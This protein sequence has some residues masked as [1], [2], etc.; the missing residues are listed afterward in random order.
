LAS[1]PRIAARLV[2]RLAAEDGVALVLGLTV[3]TVLAIVATTTVAYATQNEGSTRRSARDS[4]SYALAEAGVN[5]AAAMLGAPGRNPLDPSLLPQTTTT[6]GDGTYTRWGVLNEATGVW[7]ITSVGRTRNPTGPAVA[8][9]TRTLTVTV[10]VMPAPAQPLT[11]QAW[12]YIYSRQ[13]GLTCDMTIG[14]TVQVSSPLYVAGSLCLQNTA[15]ITKGP[16]Y[17]GGRLTMTQTANAVGSAAAPVSEA[18]IAGGCRWSTNTMHTP[19]VGGAGT[20]GFDNVWATKFD[21]TPGALAPPVPQYDSWYLNASPGP[22]YPCATVSGTPPAFD[23]DQGARTSPDA[24][25]RND[26]L[27]ALPV[28]DLTPPSSYTCKTS[29]GELSWD[30]ASRVLTVNGTVFIDGSAKVSNGMVNSYSGIGSLYLSGTLLVKGSKLCAVVTGDGSTCTTAGWTPAQRLLVVV[31]NGNGT[32]GG[33]AGQVAAGDG[34]QFVSAYFQGAVYSTYAVDID[35]T[36]RVDGPLDGST[37]KLGQSSASSFPPLAF[38]PV[39]T[40]GNP[41]V[42]PRL[43]PVGGYSG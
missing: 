5:D 15:T 33:A 42:L 21:A 29:V 22:Y 11:N 2:R 1:Q 43:G 17:V 30:A 39:A 16:L 38:V 6:L 14:N 31:T 26:S 24:T 4:Q 35:T 27:N 10:P 13:K 9:V 41:V 19:C 37:V 23:N 36:S 12:N 40:P 3:S 28:A 20:S 25:K 7:T 34:A 18:H 32:W 8:D